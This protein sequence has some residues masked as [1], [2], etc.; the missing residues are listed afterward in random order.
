MNNTHNDLYVF[1]TTVQ[2][3]SFHFK[4]SVV[5]QTVQKKKVVSLFLRGCEGNSFK[6]PNFMLIFNNLVLQNY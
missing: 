6:N 2:M 1:C 3:V 4:G 5:R